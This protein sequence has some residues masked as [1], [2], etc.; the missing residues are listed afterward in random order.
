MEGG[1]GNWPVLNLRGFSL[2]EEAFFKVDWS[3]LDIL[4]PVRGHV[5]AKHPSSKSTH[6]QKGN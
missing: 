2:A 6:T 3:G 4:R 1:V 5:R